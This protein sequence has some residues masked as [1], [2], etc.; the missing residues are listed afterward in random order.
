MPLKDDLE[1]KAKDI[2]SSRWEKRSGNVIPGDNSIGLGNDGI[3][4]DGTVLY[5]DLSSSTQLVD[6]YTPDFAAEIYKTY[7]FSAARI[8]RAEG[9]E[10]TAYD[11][12]RVM[13]VFI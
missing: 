11:G 9:G 5:A 7:L 10:V 3:E 4:M 12:D 1:T 6:T 2:F 13:G 8:I